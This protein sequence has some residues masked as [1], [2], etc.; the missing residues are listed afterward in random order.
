MPPTP[1]STSIGERDCGSELSDTSNLERPI[2]RNAKKANRK[3]KA[4]GKDLGEYLTKKLKFIEKSQEQDK[5]SLR[6][7][8]EK[9][10]LGEL[11]DTERTQLKEEKLRIEKE[12]GEEKL[13]IEKERL[14]IERKKFEMQHVTP[15]TRYSDLCP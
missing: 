12:R 10:R 13:K 2:G 9:L 7:K 15:Q 4:T 8:A 14:M 3:N 1:K 6:I 11:R 5:E